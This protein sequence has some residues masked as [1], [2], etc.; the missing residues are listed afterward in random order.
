M[1]GFVPALA[2]ALKLA[3]KAT[4]RT[5]PIW[6]SYVKQRVLQQNTRAYARALDRTLFD[7]QNDYEP[8]PPF[9]GGQCATRY[10]VFTEGRG[11]QGASG[12]V[13]LGST[14]TLPNNT[15]VHGPI[16]GIRVGSSMTCSGA[17]GTAYAGAEILCHGL[18]LTAGAPRLATQQWVAAPFGASYY[19]ISIT[20]VSRID[21]LADNCGNLFPEL[22]APAPINVNI[23]VTFGDN[24]QFNLTVPTFFFPFIV[25]VNGNLKMPIQVEI[26]PG[27]KFDGTLTLFPDFDLDLN[28]PDLSDP[29]TPGN[30]DNP[31]E[32]GPP[33]GPQPTGEPDGE[34]PEGSYV[35]GI[36][37]DLTEIPA[38]AHS[39]QG[40][41]YRGVCWVYF[42]SGEE[43]F[44]VGDGQ[45]L[46]PTQFI[47]C[48]SNNAK[49]WSV[50]FN[51][52]Y[53]GIVTPFYYKVD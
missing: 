27:A 22:P 49:N 53:N 39:Y 11:P 21:N 44:L 35:A 45:L 40:G 15:I 1:A 17:N 42:G 38:G 8:P 16:G 29:G 4:V 25:N 28:F 7:D 37:I 32:P 52:G 47:R 6:W 33:V 41:V 14:Q 50:R 20:S 9:V 18:A 24:N 46:K 51:Y 48:P 23:D 34:S 31:G 30:P 13:C 12:G 19:S 10:R 26:L 5:S 2:A 36:L 43:M 3:L